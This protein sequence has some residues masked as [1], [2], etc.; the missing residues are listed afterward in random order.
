ML[1]NN[2]YSYLARKENVNRH[3]TEN[4][5]FCI[6]RYHSYWRIKYETKFGY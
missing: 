2:M 3:K 1:M 5:W 4:V 6:V